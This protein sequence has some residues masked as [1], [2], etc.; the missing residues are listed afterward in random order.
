[1]EL[2]PERIS[3]NGREYPVYIQKKNMR[4]L[5]MRL[6]KEQDALLVHAPYFVSKRTIMIFVNEKGPRLIKRAKEKKN[7]IPSGKASIFGEIVDNDIDL[8]EKNRL[9]LEYCLSSQRKYEKIMNVPPYNV[10]VRNMT[11]RY[12]V[13]NKRTNTITYSTCLIAYSKEII[14]SIIVHELS[15]HFERNHQEGFYRIVCKYCPN[16][17]ALHKKL[18]KGEIK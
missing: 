8:E 7:A 12:G 4:S 5:T 17:K 9:L 13:N 16:Y 2:K 18:R 3:I 10:K 11:S 1:M 6:N 15:H 14:D